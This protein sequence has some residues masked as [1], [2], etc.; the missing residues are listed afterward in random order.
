[1]ADCSHGWKRSRC[2]LSNG[3]AGEVKVCESRCDIECARLLIEEVY[4]DL[5]N[6]NRIGSELASRIARF[7]GLFDKCKE[8]KA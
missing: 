7:C 8:G 1:M 6:H 3:M 5:R 2:L 4:L